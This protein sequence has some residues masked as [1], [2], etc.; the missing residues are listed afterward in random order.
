MWGD[1]NMKISEFAKKSGVTVKTLLHYDKIGLLKP[2]K[3]TDSGYRIY[4]VEDFLKLQQITTLKF[5][6]LSLDEINQILNENEHNLENIIM[7]Q[8]KALEEKKNHIES[9]IT[10]FNKAENT[11]KENG[12][13]ETQDLIDIIKITNV[14]YKVKEQY[15]TTENFSSRGKLHSYNTNSIDWDNW[16]FSK[17]EFPSNARI[18]ELGCGLGN[19]W[20]KN[21]NNIRKDLNITLSDFS[22]V[23]LQNSEEKLSEITNK[24]I[25]EKIDAQNIPYEDESFDIVIARHML[26]L[27]PDIEKALLEIKR[28][29]VKGGT[30]YVTTNSCDSMA[31]L[32][33]LIEMFD[34]SMGLNN[35]GMCERFD[36]ENGQ[37]L[38]EKYFNEVTMDILQGKIVVNDA[39]AIVAYKASTI[40][41]SSILLGEK[42][43]KFKKFI[44]NYIEKSGD[45]SIT[46][47]SCL[48]RGRK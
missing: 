2:S 15:K 3:K 25:Y 7:F 31:E 30:F 6:G 11:I 18:L 44:E 21:K 26:Y 23:M 5:I 17:M 32:N 37:P 24:L 9:V 28:V 42:R 47:K 34:S 16:C 10:V 4:C 48:F 38:L 20:S 29:L 41:G 33:K 14:E 8:K 43:M 40:K 39:E 1:T 46:T 13:L 45:I 12:S 35:N 22:D 36:A 19:L 27:V